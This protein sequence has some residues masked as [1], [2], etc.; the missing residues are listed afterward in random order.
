MRIVKLNRKLKN[1]TNLDILNKII[2][3]QN[4]YYFIEPDTL[5][6]F[7]DIDNYKNS[8]LILYTI[9]TILKS[10]NLT[11]TE[12]QP[13]PQHGLQLSNPTTKES[14]GIYHLHLRNKYILIWYLVI[15]PEHGNTI[16]LEYLPHPPP[17]DDYRTIVKD[18][19]SRDDFG[20]NSDIGE[21]FTNIPNIIKE[22]KKYISLYKTFI[23]NSKNTL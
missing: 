7:L 11:P 19:Y 15:T 16:K 8:K 17:K 20:Y 3:I 21:L 10:N 22:S 23:N 2:N 12:L 1:V 4:S 6:E 18:I 9:Y 14:Y 5:N 13:T